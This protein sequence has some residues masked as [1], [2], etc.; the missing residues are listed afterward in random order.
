VTTAD[1]AAAGSNV[2]E[3][4]PFPTATPTPSMTPTATRTPTPCAELPA[5]LREPWIGAPGRQSVR[6]QIVDQVVASKPKR[7]TVSGML[8]WESSN[9]AL[10]SVGPGGVPVDEGCTSTQDCNDDPFPGQ[11]HAAFYFQRNNAPTVFAS[12]PLGQSQTF[13][14]ATLVKGDI[15]K[16]SVN[17]GDVSNN[18]DGFSV[19]LEYT[20]VDRGC[21][22]AASP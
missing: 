11:N 10:A 22:S 9:C 4:L 19:T 12:A 2:V 20:Y 18:R 8:C 3:T 16:I 21:P 17:D 7:L 6:I 14:F 5:I 13:H 1:G 15:I